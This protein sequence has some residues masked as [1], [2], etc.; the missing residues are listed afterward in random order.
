MK[1]RP[2]E[3]K[4]HTIATYHHGIKLAHHCGAMPASAA[5]QALFIAVSHAPVHIAEAMKTQAQPWGTQ[6]SFL[7][8]IQSVIATYVSKWNDK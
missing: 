3:L 7:Y 1:N 2:N 4:D 6:Q 5:R 8:G